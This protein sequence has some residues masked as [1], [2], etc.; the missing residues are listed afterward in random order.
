MAALQVLH[1]DNHLLVVVKPA[2]TPV[3]PDESG[4][5][6]L[7]ELAKAWIAREH[8]KPG[9]V[10]LGVVHRLDRPVSGVV[11]FARTSKAA[12]RLSAQFRAREVEKRYL[13]VATG[14]P[15]PR[16]G[17]LEQWLVKD[18]R[19]NTVRAAEPEAPGARRALTRWRTLGDPARPMQL[20]GVPI[21]VLPATGRPHQIRLALASLGAPIAGDVKYG[22]PRPL[23]DKSIALHAV[24]LALVHP[25]RRERIALEA[26]LPDRAWWEPWRRLEQPEQPPEP[27]EQ[28][29][30][31]PQGT[32]P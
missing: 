16:A 24:R 15:S 22:A 7:L 14:L 31:R 12:E 2:C 8:E 11:V 21:E 28:V 9:A 1:A 30:G 32:G 10:F 5:E 29:L 19:A 3:V 4:D 17:V 23:P 20:G 13:A 27:P 26:P 25:T 6:S 18:P